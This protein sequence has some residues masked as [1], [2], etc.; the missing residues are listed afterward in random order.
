MVSCLP[1]IRRS[2]FRNCSPFQCSL[3]VRILAVISIPRKCPFQPPNQPPFQEARL[4]A[5]AAAR[6]QADAATK[7][8]ALDQAGRAG[9]TLGRVAQVCACVRVCL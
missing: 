2:F 5:A 7:K 4:A 8:A 1:L 6:A 3:Q 9:D